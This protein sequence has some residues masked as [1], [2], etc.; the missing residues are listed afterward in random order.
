MES[1]YSSLC[2]LVE[3]DSVHFIRIFFQ[4]LHQVPGNCFSFTVGVSGKI[5]LISFFG[6]LAKFG[7]QFPL[8]RMVIYFGLEII[9]HIYS[10]L[11]LGKITDMSVRCLYLI[12]CPKK[13]LLLS[14]LFAGDSTITRYLAILPLL[15]CI[16]STYTDK[17]S[18]PDIL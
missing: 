15:L 13:F 3:S 8:P 9:L 7:K 1:L 17:L 2:D 6:C 11:T 10:K 4:S 18:P 5:N 12:I 14:L 16:Q